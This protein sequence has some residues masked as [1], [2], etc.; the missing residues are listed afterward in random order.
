LVSFA[1]VETKE[2]P[3]QWMH[4]HSPNKPKNFKPTL[5][6]RK[7]ITVVFW[8]RN[9]V[10]MMEYMQQKTTIKSEMYCESVKKSAEC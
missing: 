1:N 4:T 3:K 7:L 5:S 2:Q 9:G 8:D 10:L 6:S